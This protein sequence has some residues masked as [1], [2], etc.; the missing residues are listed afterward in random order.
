MANLKDRHGLYLITN[1]DPEK[2]TTPDQDGQK[3]REK[4]P[5]AGAVDN[6][7][8]EPVYLDAG[9]TDPAWDLRHRPDT[10]TV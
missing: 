6:H 8:D 10:V 4:S 2:K 1:P 7:K 3:L 9:W 5:G